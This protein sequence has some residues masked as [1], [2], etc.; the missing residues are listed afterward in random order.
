[1]YYRQSTAAVVVYD[2][3]S[4]ASFT[5]ASSWVEELLNAEENVIIAVVGN[6]L[7]LAE[8][9]RQVPFKDASDF[10]QSLRNRGKTAFAI[11]CSALSG[12]NIKNIFEELSYRI[13]ERAAIDFE[14]PKPAEAAP[15]ANEG[16]PQPAQA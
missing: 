5:V 1:M 6:K 8:K 3:T 12:E 14:L 16:A 4:Q 13:L 15:A 10:V 11:E 7:D 9:Q 2:I